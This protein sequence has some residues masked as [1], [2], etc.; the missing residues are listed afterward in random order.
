MFGELYYL[1]GWYTIVCIS[2]VVLQWIS[3]GD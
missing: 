2:V 3:D 1:S